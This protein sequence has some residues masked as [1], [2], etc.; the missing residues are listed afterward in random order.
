MTITKLG[1]SCLLVEEKGLK[2]LIDPGVYT[3]LQNRIKGIDI[4]LITQEH[5]DH[6]STDSVQKILRN[7]PKA[8]ICTNRGAGLI[9]EKSK[10]PYQLLEHGGKLEQKGVTIEAIGR[11]HAVIYSAFPRVDNTGYLIA[12]RFFHPGD[13]LTVPKR[14]VEILALPVAGP[15]LKLSEAIDY[16]K[17]VKP[18]VCFPIHDGAF[19]PKL[20]GPY[21]SQP[22][23]VLKP[24]GIK[25]QVLDIGNPTKF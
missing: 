13:A 8:V 14:K 21:H 11:K 24:L 2:I 16:A 12:N 22:P 5:P 10:I 15:W 3:E 1:H 9:L 20:I 6:L 23:V 4:I 18:K 19:N 25:F 7:N 17:K